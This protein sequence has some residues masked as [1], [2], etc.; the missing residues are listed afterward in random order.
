MQMYN[1][2]NS[3]RTLVSWWQYYRD[4]T[5][6]RNATAIIDFTADGK[7]NALFNFQRI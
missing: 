4:E 3:F 7:N 5:V 1:S 6:F 2:N